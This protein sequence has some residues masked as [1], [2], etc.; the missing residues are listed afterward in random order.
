MTI[1][2]WIFMGLCSYIF[3]LIQGAAWGA[4]CGILQADIADGTFWTFMA[5]VLLLLV[6][7]AVS[8]AAIWGA[9]LVVSGAQKISR[10]DDGKRYVIFGVLS[11]GSAVLMAVSAYKDAKSAWDVASLFATAAASIAYSGIIAA[12]GRKIRRAGVSA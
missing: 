2:A 1:L 5:F 6:A 10:S 4:V 12:E 3:G 7:L 11:A 8:G 9:K